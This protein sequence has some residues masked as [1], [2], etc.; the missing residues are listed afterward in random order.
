MLTSEKV[1]EILSEAI[2]LDKEAVN[3]LFS[4]RTECNDSLAN[5]P[6]I[7]VSEDSKV[8]LI[9]LLNGVLVDSGEPRIAI[10]SD[11]DVIVGFDIYPLDKKE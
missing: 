11:N 2:V 1:I 4:Y 8:G 5:H 6:T 3:R 7:A 10:V 9:G